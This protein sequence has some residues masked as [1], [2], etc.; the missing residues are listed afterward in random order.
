MLELTS[1]RYVRSIVLLLPVISLGIVMSLSVGRED[2]ASVGG[3]FRV[4][5]KD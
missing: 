4:R 3:R 2:L 5:G 1:K